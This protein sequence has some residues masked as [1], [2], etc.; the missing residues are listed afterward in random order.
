MRIW[1]NSNSWKILETGKHLADF[2]ELNPATQF[3][4]DHLTTTSTRLTLAIPLAKTLHRRL[5]ADLGR[6]AAPEWQPLGEKKGYTK[7][8]TENHPCVLEK[9]LET[10]LP[11]PG[12]HGPQVSSY[13][14]SA[15]VT[16][17]GGITPT[18]GDIMEIS[19]EKRQGGRVISYQYQCGNICAIVNIHG[20][21]GLWSSN[22]MNGNP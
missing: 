15:M 9:I 18:T 21:Y 20:I 3:Q 8:R 2:F 4:L 13:K 22:I 16:K 7:L 6:N 11:T 14:K 17:N 12:I 10:S 1:E 5:L 19:L